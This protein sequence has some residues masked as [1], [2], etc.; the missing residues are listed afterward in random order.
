MDNYICFNRYFFLF[1]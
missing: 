1:M